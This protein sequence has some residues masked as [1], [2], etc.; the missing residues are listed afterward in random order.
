MTA[1]VSQAAQALLS[2]LG[3]VEP[4]LSTKELKAVLALNYI[5]N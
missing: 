1:R 3:P 5:G 2:I 4:N